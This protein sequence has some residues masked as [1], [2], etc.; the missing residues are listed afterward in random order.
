MFPLG[1]S[2][3][4]VSPCR[5][6]IFICSAAAFSGAGGGE[7]GAKIREEEKKRSNLDDEQKAL[8]Q[9]GCRGVELLPIKM[10]MD[11]LFGSG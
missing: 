6:F 7:R 11:G 4:R 10:G 1:L 5:F 3:K 9:S 2:K 8:D